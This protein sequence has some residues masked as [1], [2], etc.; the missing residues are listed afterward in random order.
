LPERQRVDANP[1]KDILGAVSPD[2]HNTH[3]ASI[4]NHKAMALTK[5]TR[6][7]MSTHIL[8]CRQQTKRT[9]TELRSRNASKV[10]ATTSPHLVELRNVND[11][12]LDMDETYRPA[13]QTRAET[14]KVDSVRVDCILGI[15]S[16]AKHSFNLAK[17]Q[18]H[19]GV[20]QRIESPSCRLGLLDGQ[21]HA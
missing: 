17:K 4:I 14:N 20:E 13:R 12:P 2:D 5:E 21:L 16:R 8:V 6:L 15:N 3:P 10:L 1:M 11:V 18:L 7:R 19:M 9:E